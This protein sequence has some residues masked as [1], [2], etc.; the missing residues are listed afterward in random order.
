[1][2]TGIHL[3][4]FNNCCNNF[5]KQLEKKVRGGNTLK[6]DGQPVYKTISVME[7][8]QL[9]FAYNI[10]RNFDANEALT[11][12][13]EKTSSLYHITNI[14]RLLDILSIQS[15]IRVHAK[16]D[17]SVVTPWMQIKEDYQLIVG[18]RSRTFCPGYLIIPV[19]TAN[20]MAG[21]M[22][23]FFPSPGLEDD[24][25]ESWWSTDIPLEEL[26]LCVPPSILKEE[27]YVGEKAISIKKGDDSAYLPCELRLKDG[28]F[29]KIRNKW[30]E[31]LG[32]ALLLENPGYVFVRFT[33]SFLS[34]ANN[35]TLF[36]ARKMHL[37]GCLLW[38]E[39]K[40]IKHYNSLTLQLT[41][42]DEN[43]FGIMEIKFQNAVFNK[44]GFLCFDCVA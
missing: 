18:D 27:R 2:A 25:T 11:K 10:G 24:G 20:L 42:I 15:I 29:V 31:V 41:K 6:N 13:D 38:I 44:L 8:N 14:N 40:Y 5:L 43:Q 17:C 22:F 4:F 30:Y 34:S 16:G 28:D 33:R 37:K 19:K 35:P 7:I 39:E 9:I 12:A 26:G 23:C 1:M 3:K 21:M 32:V 36:Y